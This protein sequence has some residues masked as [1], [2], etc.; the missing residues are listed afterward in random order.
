MINSNEA[1]KSNVTG[2]QGQGKGPG[3][4]QEK[5]QGTRTDANKVTGNAPEVKTEANKV[6]EKA[7]QLQV[8]EQHA[9][10][11]SNTG[12]QQCPEFCYPCV[13]EC[14]PADLGATIAQLMC[15]VT[16]LRNENCALKH[17]KECLEHD[18][19]EAHH[20]IEC[21][22][23]EKQCL[24]D[25]VCALFSQICCLQTENGCLKNAICTIKGQVCE[26]TGTIEEVECLPPCQPCYCPPVT[27]IVPNH[28][29][30]R[31]A[32]TAQPLE[33]NEMYNSPEAPIK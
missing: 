33:A 23:E 26:I 6:T 28:P 17:D 2:T 21:L 27:P 12:G 32:E 1:G 11:G 8:P 20:Q 29:M 24:Q 3:A 30:A 16:H 9:G 25:R 4:T 7:Q 10:M 19:C 31:E 22:C 5:T 14:T 18:L 15:T 13:D